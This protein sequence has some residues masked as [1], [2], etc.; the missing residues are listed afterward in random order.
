IGW[1]SCLCVKISNHMAWWEPDDRPALNV[2]RRITPDLEKLNADGESEI[3]RIHYGTNICSATD[4]WR[5][6]AA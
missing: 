2:I 4:N 1:P 5:T 3:G 6:E